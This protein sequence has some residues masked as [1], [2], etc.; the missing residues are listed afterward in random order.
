MSSISKLFPVALF[1][2]LGAA[3]PA[4]AA[5]TQTLIVPFSPA[6]GPDIVARS[7]ADGLARETG[8]TVVVENRTGASGEIGARFVSRANPDGL[9]LLVAADPPL[10]VNQF[11]KKLAMPNPLQQFEPISELATGTMALV[12]S[13]A[14]KATDVKS[15]VEY[16]KAN[17]DRIN[18]GSPGIGTPQH[19]TMEF[20]KS[21]AGISVQ[22]VPFKDAAGAT[23]ALLGG[24]I[25]AAF[26]PIQVALP[27]PRDRVRILGVSSA[28]RVKSAS[29]IPTISEQGYPG[30]ES[31]FRVGILAPKGTPADLVASY[32]KIL[33]KLVSAPDIVE[34][35]SRLGM[36]PLGSSP[37]EYAKT[38]N[39]D[40]AK[41]RKVIS[42]AKIAPE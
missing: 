7:V 14:L 28:Q 20:F 18:Y 26:L 22:H 9:T 6:S 42:D 31:Y 15:F 29:D 4:K 39:S 16:A 17:P 30:F 36:V 11:V 1:L 19:L 3:M 24:L 27:L 13:D 34:R 41:W 8:N 12:V 37:A 21:A 32:S 38:L 5:D 35:F 23:S 40:E 2:A 33:A 10:T 25:S